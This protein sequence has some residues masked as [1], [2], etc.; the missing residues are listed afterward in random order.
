MDLLEDELL[1]K[2]RPE[3]RRT[4][5]VLAT[6]AAARLGSA[7]R[8]PAA[9]SVGEGRLQ[10]V[11]PACRPDAAGAARGGKNGRRLAPRLP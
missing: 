10:A 8:S 4:V 1:E 5:L 2:P 3:P 6:P 9:A 11:G 7:R